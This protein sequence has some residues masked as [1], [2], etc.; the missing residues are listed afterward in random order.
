MIRLVQ[1]LEATARKHP[2]YPAV[3]FNGCTSTWGQV[4]ESARR[5]GGALSEMGVKPGDAVGI[6][7]FNSDR[8]MVM[9]YAPF[10]ADAVMAQFNYRWAPREMDMAVKDSDPRVLFVDRAH[11]EEGRRLL[12]KHEGIRHLVLMDEPDGEDDVVHFDDMAQKGPLSSGSNRANTD[13]AALFFT[14]GT[15]GRSKAVMLSHQNLFINAMGAAVSYDFPRAQRFLQSAP[16]FHL[17]AGA[18]IYTLAYAASHAVMMD[19]F[20]PRG[21]LEL[22][23]KEKINDALLVPTMANM[24]FNHPDLGEFDLRSLVRISYG[25]A[26]MPEPLLREI[27]AKLPGVEFYQGYGMTETSPVVTVLPPEAH[28]PD[29]PLADKLSSIGKPVDHCDV[30]IGDESGRELPRGEVGEIMLRGPNVMLGYL[31]LP[32]VTAN[33]FMNGWLR[34]GD[35]AYQDEDGYV[36]LVDRVK[37]MIISGGE[38]IYS[39]EVE[40]ILYEHPAIR[41]CAVIGLK[42]KK[43]GERVHAVITLRPG[44][45]VTPED[46][47]EFCRVRIAHYKC[48]KTVEII[49]EMPI[50]GANKVLK[51]QLRAERNK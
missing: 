43:W 4:F 46:L 38:N 25:A 1:F 44:K 39:N 28:D 20:D 14:G 30:I 36:F 49:E 41:E 32:D 31:G 21:A 8:H 34:T 35:G 27:M 10:Y 33:S 48:P 50:S 42:D 26:P 22:I 37:D 45:A 15:T 19:H 13:V 40:S 47:I 3:T 5:I 12:A 7:A 24:L 11:L 9:F 18:R 23:E 17:A 6:L 29:G 51:S 2:D 16:I